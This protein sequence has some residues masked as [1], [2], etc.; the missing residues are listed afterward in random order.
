MKYP[1]GYY[2]RG[3][4]FDDEAGARFAHDFNVLTSEKCP[5]HCADCLQ[6]FRKE[7]AEIVAEERY[8]EYEKTKIWVPY[9]KYYYYK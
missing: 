7:M 3:Y 4:Y 8:Q 6:I 9:N 1:R 2:P 5:I